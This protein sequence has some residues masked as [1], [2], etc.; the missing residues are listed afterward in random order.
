[1]SDATGTVETKKGKDKTH[2]EALD[3][4]QE[5]SE[6][7]RVNREDALD[8][9]KF[10]IGEQWPDD[11]ARARKLNK[12]PC[13][14]INRIP[15]FIR[16][17]TGDIRQNKPAIKVL[18]VEDTDKDMADVFTGIIRHIEQSSNAQAAYINAGEGAASCGMGWFRIATEYSS[19]DSFEQDIKIKIGKNHFA[20]WCDPSAQEIDK[21]DARYAF[22]TEL[23][24]LDDFKA[25]FPKASTE[26]F[27]EKR[28]VTSSSV[29]DTDWWDGNYI[30]VAEYWTRKPASKELAMLE[31]G[32]VIDISAMDGAEVSKLPIKRKRLA[33]G[34]KVCS[35]LMNGSEILEGPMEWAGKYIPIIFVTG[36]EISLG[37]RVVR[38]GL[39]RFAKDPQRMFNYMRS[40]S[41]E[42][43]ALQP[44]APWVVTKDE[45]KGHEAQWNNAH[46]ENKPYL[47][48][49]PDAKAGGRPQRVEPPAPPTALWAEGENAAEDM[50][51]ATGI[52]PASLG[53]KSNETSGKAI[54]A[55]Q[56]ESDTGTM[57]YVDNLANA[58]AYCGRQLVDLIPKIYDTERNIRILGEDDSQKFVTVN[59][60]TMEG[61]RP[62]LL[63]DLSAGKYDVMVA[64]GPSY[65][66]KR[67]EAAESMMAFLQTNPALAPLIGDLVATNMDWPGADKIA[68]RMR[69]AAGI[70]DEGEDG[71]PAPPPPVDPLQLIQ[72]L[73]AKTQAEAEIVKSA[74]AKSQADLALQQAQ[75]QTGVVGGV[76]P[77]SIVPMI[78]EGL[79]AEL[80]A[81]GAET[82]QTVQALQVMAQG[83]LSYLTAPKE[84]VRGADGTPLAVRPVMGGPTNA[85]D[86]LASLAQPRA[87]ALDANGRPA[88]MH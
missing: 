7:D 45:I 1:M 51:A 11:I 50:H 80:Q 2:Q 24:S 39:I 14:T 47:L 78:V 65:T 21:S 44:K 83:I 43:I 57:V 76:D 88:G 75:M 5:A 22:V 3:R 53:A 84:I 19:D 46:V 68:E 59:K 81:S 30:R 37:D 27:E 31:D 77:A 41:A 18:P 58:I 69:K 70:P 87:I 40:A 4:F 32:S 55:R 62:V 26:D 52:Y 85:A 13:L 79:R 61:G 29:R 48:F 28:P 38:H 86:G 35:Y 74:A 17:V 6:A 25:R 49:N 20:A 34:F 67:A 72:G 8:D 56:R 63:N 36:E 16:Q 33:N 10:R 23:Y 73:V 12:R 60:A 64:T 15:Q 42:A 66:T 9:L 71:E 54:L 82:A